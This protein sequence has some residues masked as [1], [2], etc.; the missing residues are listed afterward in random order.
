MSA[1][2]EERKTIKEGSIKTGM[3]NH[4]VSKCSFLPSQTKCTNLQIT[5]D[6]GIRAASSLKHLQAQ[7]FHSSGK[8]SLGSSSPESACLKFKI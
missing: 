2:E 4:R 6:N 8:E 7:W 3:S 5:A 1:L